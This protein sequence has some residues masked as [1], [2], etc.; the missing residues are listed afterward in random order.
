MSLRRVV[1]WKKGSQMRSSTEVST[2]AVLT[3]NGM[4]A[5]DIVLGG[6]SKVDEVW[7]SRG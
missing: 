1:K 7:D 2:A 4:F 6:L 5:R 3:C